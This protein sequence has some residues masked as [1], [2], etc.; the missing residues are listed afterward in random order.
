MKP[1][2]IAGALAALLGSPA[3]SQP[4]PGNATQPAV[5]A[6]NSG[7]EVDSGVGAT[8]PQSF[9]GRTAMSADGREIGPIREAQM[10]GDTSDGELLV[11]EHEG[12][13]LR[14]PAS[15]ASVSGERVT[16]SSTFDRAIAN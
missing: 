13:M 9:V 6:L 10:A 2:L 1:L 5:P 7:E 11:V 15:G 14:L 3:L 8:D 12:R 16:V 4:A